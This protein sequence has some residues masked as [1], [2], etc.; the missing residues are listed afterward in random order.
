MQA[1]YLVNLREIRQIL[2]RLKNGEAS[3]RW[4]AASYLGSLGRARRD[5]NLIIIKALEIAKSGDKDADVR[6]MAQQSIRE[7]KGE[8][9][10]ILAR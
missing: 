3:E 10:K 7:A 9:D 6:I 8:L 5:L 1:R 4:S 2:H